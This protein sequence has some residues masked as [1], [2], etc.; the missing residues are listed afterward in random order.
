LLH[1]VFDILHQIWRDE[2]AVLLRGP[3]ASEAPGAVAAAR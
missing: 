3:A 2:R 1:V